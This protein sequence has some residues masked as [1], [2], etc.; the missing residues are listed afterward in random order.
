MEGDRRRIQGLGRVGA[1]VLRVHRYA[2]TH[3]IFS[4]ATAAEEIGISFPTVAAAADQ[5]GR[6]GVVREITGR[7]RGRLFAY[8]GYLDILSEGTEPIGQVSAAS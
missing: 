8:A 6:L 5:M 7:Q 3:P 4:I 1:S 2:Q